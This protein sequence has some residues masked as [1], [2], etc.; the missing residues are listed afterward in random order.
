M[1]L[2]GSVAEFR[3]RRKARLDAIA[4]YDYRER[5]DQRW[6]ARMDA[7]EEENSNDGGGGGHGNTKIPFGLC[8]REG[9]KVDP[10][11]TPKDAWDA[12]AGKGYSA[13]E[14]YKSLKETGKVGGKTKVKKPPTEIK[15][16]HF[17]SPMVSG[18][19]KKNT[20]EFA[21]FINEHCDD[22]DVTEF[23]SASTMKGAKVPPV[24]S[25]KRT[26]D[27]GSA[28]VSTTYY[29]SSGKIIESKIKIPQ[30][31]GIKD[32][33]KK[34][35]A[36]RTFAHEWTHYVDLC[37]RSNDRYG[38]YSDDNDGLHKVIDA[39]DGSVGEE[40]RREFTKFNEKFDALRNEA[41]KARINATFEVAEKMFGGRPS[42]LREDGS[43]SYA[44]M[45]TGGVSYSQIKAYEKAVKKARKD[46]DIDY[47][48]R[49]R[50]FMNGVSSLQ[51]LYDSLNAGKLRANGTVKYGHPE[52]YFKSDPK[53][54]A[55][56]MFA[57]YVALK[58]TNPKLLEI[59]ERDKPQIAEKLNEQLVEI[60]KRMRGD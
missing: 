37:A 16:S 21:K 44:G 12:L 9:I 8:L 54:K 43:A 17:P 58:A 27:I 18:A 10:N 4:V 35:S 57:D 41:K 39:D 14:V 24:V 40:A 11:W 22:G 34:A 19:Y 20:M 7:E 29:T 51:G 47:N 49:K 30:F 5:R 60:T 23:F 45:L 46:V 2:L 55:I 26:T 56:E 50:A 31:S 32:E 1:F 6:I 33:E 28:G 36:M 48:D 38:H 59:F 15:E 52:S 42:W 13:G 53:N 3:K 25:C